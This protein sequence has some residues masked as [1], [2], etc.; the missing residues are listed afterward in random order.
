[1]INLEYHKGNQCSRKE[2]LCQEGYCSSC[3]IFWQTP[4]FIPKLTNINTEKE[5]V[6]LEKVPA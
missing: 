2:I 4:M 6:K 5:L 3:I 1:M